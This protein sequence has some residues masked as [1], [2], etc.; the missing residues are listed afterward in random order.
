LVLL[1]HD[2]RALVAA[3]GQAQRAVDYLN[4]AAGWAPTPV[5]DPATVEPARA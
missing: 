5:A 1:K 3:C 2:S 4:V